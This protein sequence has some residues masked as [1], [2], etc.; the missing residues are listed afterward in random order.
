MAGSSQN[1]RLLVLDDDDSV[2]FTICA[3]AEGAGFTTRATTNAGDFFQQLGDWQPSHIILDLQM[4]DI[5]GIEVLRRLADAGNDSVITITSGLGTRVLEAAARVAG[6][7]GL[8]IAGVL[9]KPFSA[10]T[11]RNLLA[12]SGESPKPKRQSPASG[13]VRVSSSE[14]T[15]LKAGLDAN[16]LV[17][18][19]QPK[20]ACASGALVGFE[21]LARWLH[22]KRGMVMPDRFIPL[23]ERSGLIHPLTRQI[24]SQALAWFRPLFAGT[25]VKLALNMS[26]KLL[27]D[28]TFPT[29]LMEQ[30][31]REAVDPHQIIL[32]ITETSSMADPVQLLE[33]LTQLRIK[34]FHL[35]IDDFG[36]GYSSLI[37]LARLPFSE[38]K[39][40][41]MFVMTAPKSQESQKIA[42]AIV[43]L[44]RALAL[45]VTAEGL[46][47]AWTLEF[48]RNI[49]C[50]VAQGYLISRPVDGDTA[51]AWARA[52]GHL[53]PI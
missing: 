25:E 2:T 26:P 37:Q 51:L 41:K 21:T 52:E 33:Y 50:D 15:E 5:D 17:P 47:D 22:P 53:P 40:D 11:L 24:F 31:A 9:A 38:M 19:Y 4:P 27:S 45:S 1:P 18:F 14:F 6:E 49:G 8:R 42:T 32:E 3:I 46:E 36:V 44:A 39:I 48:L 35:S 29:W 16:Q 34:G 13:D 23:A 43:G 10:A 20:I 7:N 28:P 30:C 12:D